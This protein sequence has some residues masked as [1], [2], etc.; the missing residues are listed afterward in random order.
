MSQ[1]DTHVA[2]PQRRF[3]ETRR[4]DAWW[5][6]PV[7]VAAGLSAFII[8]S[9]WAALQGAHYTH[10]GYLS[11][12]YS[13]EIFG[14]SSHSLFGPFPSWWPSFIPASPEIGRAH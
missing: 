13:P 8:Y 4:T 5:V 9:T 10:V 12:F 2:L 3:R 11:P 7:A 14:D 1:A 6:Q